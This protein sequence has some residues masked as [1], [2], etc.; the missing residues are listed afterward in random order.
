MKFLLLFPLVHAGV[1]A[2][3]NGPCICMSSPVVALE[4]GRSVVSAEYVGSFAWSC[5][6]CDAACSV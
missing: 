2:L 5:A 3:H 1:L 6:V 4:A